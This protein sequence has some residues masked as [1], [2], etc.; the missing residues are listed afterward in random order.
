ME[1]VGTDDEMMDPIEL[2]RAMRLGRPRGDFSDDDVTGGERLLIDGE[3]RNF[4]G[5]SNFQVGRETLGNAIVRGIRRLIGWK[6]TYVILNRKDNRIHFQAGAASPYRAFTEGHV[7]TGS[8]ISAYPL[9]EAETDHFKYAEEVAALRLAEAHEF[10]PRLAIANWNVARLRSFK[11]KKGQRVE[12]FLRSVGVDTFVLTETS[13]AVK[14][15]P[16]FASVFTDGP[17]AH[18]KPD[19]RWAAI[20]SRFP[21]EQSVRT[22]D[23]LRSVAA[24]V[25]PPAM[26][27]FLVYAMVLPAAHFSWYDAPAAGGKAF[28][29]A[30][31]Y[32]VMDVGNIRAAHPDLDLFVAGD[33][34]QDLAED[35]HYGSAFKKQALREALE[36]ANLIPLTAGPNDPVRAASAPWACIDHISV[37]SAAWRIRRS[38]RWPNLPEP[39]TKLSDHFGVA[40]EVVRG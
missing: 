26:P 7:Q 9:S 17:D 40:L 19:E 28:V 11:S 1:R 14:P 13:L 21:L 36:E 12:L 5:F 18:H 22:L 16:T 4:W 6:C 25:S 30:L 35:Q 39:D 38:V 33:F 10:P 27:P 24:V 29:A 15:G 37:S 20:H 8:E 34:N 31:G 3:L 32:F 2:G 23:P